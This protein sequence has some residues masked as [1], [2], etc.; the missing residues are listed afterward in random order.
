[1]SMLITVLKH[2]V[3]QKNVIAFR[4]YLYLSLLRII[5]NEFRKKTGQFY[6][7]LFIT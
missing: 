1:M 2:G 7:V 5:H 6:L 4:K 3:S